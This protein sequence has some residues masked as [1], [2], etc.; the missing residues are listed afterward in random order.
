MHTHTL[1]TFD[2][3]PLRVHVWEPS[4]PKGLVL[5]CHD[6]G[7]HSA[8]FDGL[9]EALAEAGFVTIAHDQR[10]FGA[11]AP[12]SQ[13]GHG[14]AD[15][16][17]YSLQDIIFLY[18]YYLREYGLPIYLLGQGYG[19][20]L[21]LGALQR[22]ILHPAGVMLMSVG[23]LSTQ[24]M[25]AALTVLKGIPVKDSP[26]TLSLPLMQALS[27]KERTA[28]MADAKVSDPLWGVVPTVAFDT[29]M[30]EGL[31]S[32]F[33]PEGVAKWDR[34]VPY[35]L[36]AGMDDPNLGKEGEAAVGML[37]MM[38]RWGFEPRFFGYQDV[39]HDILH[40][41]VAERCHGHILHFLADIE[42]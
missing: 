42:A 22:G 7:E 10:G 36:L 3:T 17:E 33:S 26:A 11:T 32:V 9:A 39:R 6:V 38:R 4:D 25:R 34:N 23:L 2:S 8:R 40:S 27:S 19:G 41:A 37:L 30:L 1:P 14:N 28:T 21:I 35:A 20:Y 24:T 5:A 12:T 16:F 31:L 18:R 29:A 15:T 13:L